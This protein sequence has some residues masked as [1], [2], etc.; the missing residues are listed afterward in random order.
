MRLTLFLIVANV[1]V[2]VYSLTDFDYFISTY[3]F[4]TAGFLAV[5]Y[6]IIITSLFIHGDIIHLLNNM[7]ALF[8]LGVVVEKNVKP[9]EYLLVYF[10]SGVFGNMS[11]F[12]PIFGFAPDTLAVGASAAISGLVGLGIFV[13]PWAQVLFPAVFPLPFVVAGALYFLTTLSN[14]FAQ[15]YIAYPAHMFGILGGAMFGL[16]WGEQK[17]RRLAIF[18]FFLLLIP[19]LPTIISY[20]LG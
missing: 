19:C 12:V 1:L 13:N 7:I 15:G 9:W 4:S 14:L 11:M 10:S 5:E 2:F 18:V 20:L 17:L 8:F 6:H 3:G 16:A